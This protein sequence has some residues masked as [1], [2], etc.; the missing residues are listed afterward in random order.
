MGVYRP[1]LRI[2]DRASWFVLC[3]VTND[4]VCAAANETPNANFPL[5]GCL[6][7]HTN[8]MGSF[9]DLVWVVLALG[10]SLGWAHSYIAHR[11]ENHQIILLF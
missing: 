5:F 4:W 10:V 8:G 7:P 2:F 11:K 6:H 3:Y 9:L 1:L